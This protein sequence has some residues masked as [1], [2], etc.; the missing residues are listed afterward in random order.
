[1]E[2]SP[3]V[4]Y[5]ICSLCQNSEDVLFFQRALRKLKQ[6]KQLHRIQWI[7]DN[8]TGIGFLDREA[9][10]IDS[11]AQNI[12]QSQVKLGIVY[13]KSEETVIAICNIKIFDKLSDFNNEKQRI[14]QLQRNEVM[15][16]T[17]YVTPMEFNLDL[18]QSTT[19]FR[20]LNIKVD[21][22]LIHTQ[23]ISRT[24]SSIDMNEKNQ[25]LK[26]V[27]IQLIKVPVFFMIKYDVLFNNN[28]SI[29]KIFKRVNYGKVFKNILFRNSF[30]VLFIFGF[31][32]DRR[33]VLYLVKVLTESLI[34]II[35]FVSAIFNMQNN[36]I[37]FSIVY[38]SITLFLF[39]IERIINKASQYINFTSLLTENAVFAGICSAIFIAYISFRSLELIRE[40][41]G[42]NYNRIFTDFLI[43]PTNWLI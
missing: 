5:A 24:P 13:Q 39:L 32:V 17:F 3:L 11:N 1:L 34:S 14:L 26:Q 21:P 33:F 35:S 29:F 22:Y 31:L 8:Q 18:H 12:P 30:V 42:L 41:S 38:E 9:C 43:N 40:K 2:I 10:H 6:N 4:F 36:K 23:F 25:I 19:F 37:L 27:T 15:N 28:S 16:Y 7:N 20:G